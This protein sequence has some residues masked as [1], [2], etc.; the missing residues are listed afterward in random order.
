MLDEL[1][2]GGANAKDDLQNICDPDELF[3]EN[4]RQGKVELREGECNAKDEC[5]KDS[6]VYCESKLVAVVIY[7]ATVEAPI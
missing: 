1:V 5:K 6:G 3:R 2:N 7:A 4:P